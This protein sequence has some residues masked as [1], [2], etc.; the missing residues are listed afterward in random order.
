LEIS[1][2]LQLLAKKKRQNFGASQTK[3]P[4][5]IFGP[6]HFVNALNSRNKSVDACIENA[7]D[8]FLNFCYFSQFF[9]LSASF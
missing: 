3:V 6:S 2:F 5:R 7:F 8:R 1:H 4:K 9:L